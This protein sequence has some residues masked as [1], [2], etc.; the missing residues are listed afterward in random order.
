MG[1]RQVRANLSQF[2]SLQRF[3]RSLLTAW[4]F[5]E[6]RNWPTFRAFS[7]SP[8]VSAFFMAGQMCAAA[9]VTGGRF[10]PSPPGN[11]EWVNG[12]PKMSNLRPD[13]SNPR[14]VYS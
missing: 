2:H 11:Q 3:P 10:S 4:P 14:G 12:W 9:P 13:N 8:F 1:G 7:V 5:P 6:V